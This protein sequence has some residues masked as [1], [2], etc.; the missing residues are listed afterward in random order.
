MTNIKHIGDHLMIHT[1]DHKTAY[2]LDPWE[3]LGPKRRKLL[4]NSWASLFR[5][6][7]LSE[8]PVS[9]LTSYY[10]EDFGRPTKELYSALGA[11]VIQQMHDLT[12]D[13]AVAQFS[14][15]LQWH[16]ALDIPGESDEAKYLSAKSLWTLRQR[17]METG[18]DEVLFNITANTLARVF[19]VDTSK[20][21]I[22]SVHIRSNMK[23][24]GRICIFSQSIHNFLVNLKRHHREIF[25]TID[26]EI[27]E[28]YL[29]KKALGC[30][31]LVKPSE[32]AK[33]LEQVSKDLF[34]LVQLFRDNKQVTSMNTFGV[35]LRVLAEQ[36]E[37]RE[38]EN[39][40][41]ELTLKKPCDIPSSSLQNPSDPDA[42]YSSH[43]GQGYHVQ[44]METYCDCE[45]G[46]QR[47]EALGD[48]PKNLDNM[49]SSESAQTE[50][51]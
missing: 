44:V 24:L 8:L 50:R 23:R 9:Q 40:C 16:Y 30:F 20:Q 25:D 33:T 1:R 34:S 6:H 12:D 10:S 29:T 5:E 36:C 41:Q 35:L 27:V 48:G 19:G 22:D 18:L 32:S 28:R 38:E 11:L 45:E 4:D 42:G 21:R 3:Y 17:V 31:S 49:L 7:I 37:V 43:K 47:E 46:N 14:F 13:E 2:M 39:S 15:N 26:T 51:S